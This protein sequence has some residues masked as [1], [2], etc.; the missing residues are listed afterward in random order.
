KIVFVLLVAIALADDC[1]YF[2]CDCVADKKYQDNYNFITD[3][4]RK[5]VEYKREHYGYLTEKCNAKEVQY[6]IETTYS[7]KYKSETNN[8]SY[9]DRTLSANTLVVKT[10][11]ALEQLKC[12]NVKVDEVIDLMKE[13]TKCTSSVLDSF[14][15]L[16]T[17]EEASEITIIDAE[18]L[19]PENMDL[20]CKMDNVNDCYVVYPAR[21]ILYI[22]YT[23]AVV[24][25][26]TV[27]AVYVLYVF[28]SARKS[29]PV[30]SAPTIQVT[31]KEE[32]EK[33]EE[34]VV[35]SAPATTPALTATAAPATIPAQPTQPSTEPSQT[36]TERA[37]GSAPAPSTANSA[38][39][40]NVEL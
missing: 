39:N 37:D 11:A 30:K 28:P 21:T 4:T 7:L 16:N 32:A 10:A 2:V 26:V 36:T 13:K 14:I 5:A 33:K 31:N 40:Q 24:M 38:A 17:E 34:T 8:T 9:Y 35:S 6:V 20:R 22:M 25:V 27:V 23:L 29:L 3:A 1:G 19:N 12:S 18:M 15:N